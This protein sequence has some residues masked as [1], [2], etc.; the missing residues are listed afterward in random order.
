MSDKRFDPKKAASL[1]RDERKEMLPPEKIINHLQ[2]N[3]HDNVADLGAGN[4]YFAIPIAKRTK[5]K[6]YAV[7][8]EPK[9]L[10]MLQ[11]NATKEG[12]DNIAYVESN[13]DYIQLADNAVN[14]IIIAFVMHEVPDVNQ[15]LSE[16]KR[17][18]EPDGH[19]LILDWEAVETES[20][21]P[22]HHRISSIEMKKILE[23]NGFTAVFID[24]N[25]ENYGV[26]AVPK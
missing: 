13:L 1:F 9:M 16:I 8:V 23:Q 5:G 24:I 18:L 21:P 26:L 22:I 10:A 4:G 11:E 15:T 19:M 3:T 14:K 20:G 25:P 12:V 2:I 7:D 6:V 17:I